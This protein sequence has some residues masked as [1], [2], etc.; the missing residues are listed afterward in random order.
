M[1]LA[2][3]EPHQNVLD[4]HVQAD[5]QKQ[6]A[7][8]AGMDPAKREIVEELESREGEERQIAS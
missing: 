1:H 3:G 6:P 4:L 7:Q 5:V 2:E 8:R